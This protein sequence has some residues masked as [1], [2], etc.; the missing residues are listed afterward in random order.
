MSLTSDVKNYFT[1]GKF[2][3]VVLLGIALSGLASFVN[4]YDAISK[5]NV[6][7]K[8][9][10]TDLLKKQLRTKFIVM[11]VISCLAI[12]LGIALGDL[13]KYPTRL[14]ML[15]LSL[16]G[17]FGILYAVITKYNKV[18]MGT[19]LGISWLLF[20]VFIA[21]GFILD[22][23]KLGGGEKIESETGGANLFVM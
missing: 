21:L 23:G 19:K 12:V 18:S 9:Q 15:G 20:L 22:S 8:L 17:V 4:T 6:I 14:F 5:I 11:I 13:K 1:F 2:Q 16:A 3:F 10:K 7:D